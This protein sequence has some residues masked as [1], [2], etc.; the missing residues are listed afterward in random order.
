MTDLFALRS[1]GRT[2]LHP[3]VYSFEMHV[4][5]K[6]ASRSSAELHKHKKFIVFI[7]E[8]FR[9]IHFFMMKNFVEFWCS[10]WLAAIKQY[11]DL[12]YHADC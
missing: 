3:T 12:V 10:N 1:G 11:L 7:E 5:E 2:G 8:C 4:A 6:I 9:N